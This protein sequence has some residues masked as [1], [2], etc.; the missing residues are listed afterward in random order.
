MKTAYNEQNNFRR[1]G[2]KIEKTVTGYDVFGRPRE[3]TIQLSKEVVMDLHGKPF[4][5][6]IPYY[7]KHI[8][9]PSHMDYQRIIGRCWNVYHPLECT[10]QQ[11]EHPT[12]DILMVRVF[13]EQIE[14]GWD[15]LTL[16]YQRPTQILPVLCLVSAENHT[17]KS[18]FGNALSYLFGQNVG[19]CTQD[20]LSSSF[21][22]W[23]RYLF[24]VFEEISETKTTLNKIKAMSTA[25]SATLNQKYKQQ[26]E[27]QPFVK[28]VILSNNDRSF[29]KA[30]EHDIR[31]WVRRL[32]PIPK[33]E[34]IADF[35]DRL[36]Q[37]VP[38]LMH[39]LLHR[40]VSVAQTSR[41][42]FQPDS[43]RTEALDKVRTES[44]SDIVKDLELLI[45]EKL[46]E[47]YS[48]YATASKLGELLKNKYPISK[49]AA[50]MKNDL[51]YE[52]QKQMRYKDL[53]G[54][55]RNGTPYHFR[56]D[57]SPYVSESNEE[58]EPWDA[59]Y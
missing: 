32:V 21:N 56:R 30:N 47:Y 18:S 58:E 19:F 8:I 24:A 22:V 20:D 49:I 34:F 43:L 50:A 5:N 40:E 23:I 45:A 37:E 17:G 29:I 11:G 4:L 2:D 55:H 13:R 48:F 54:E 31:Y 44:R 51:G 53:D 52:P 33:D 41:M 39:T 57:P 27:F 3:E 16:A 15:Y 42:W 28:L 46:D 6:Q 12:W 59:P 10:P 7:E 26:I 9:V 25:R 36:R 14:L 1:V 35:D 38:A